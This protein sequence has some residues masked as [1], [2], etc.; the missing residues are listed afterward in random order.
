MKKFQITAGIL[1]LVSLLMIGIFTL[2]QNSLG[3]RL[4][5]QSVTERW[6]ADGTRYAQLSAFI[7][8]SAGV[9]EDS[10]RHSMTSSLDSAYVEASI[11]ANENARLYAY[12]YSGETTVSVS[13]I[14]QETG[15]T[16]KSGVT[17]TA[18][19]VGG[20]FF[21][22]HRLKLLSG[23]YID[24]NDLVLN[25]TIIMDN[26]LAWQF[27]GSPDVVGQS[28]V[29]NGKTCYISGVCEP[30]KAYEEF[31]GENPRIYMSY[32]LLNELVGL[33]V[34]CVETCMPDPVKNFAADILKKSLN[35]PENQIEIIENSARFTDSGLFERLKTFSERSVRTKLVAYPYWENA[36][37]I[38]VDRAAILYVGKLVPIA[39][40]VLLA[41]IELVLAYRNRKRFFGFVGRK[42]TAWW[43]RI[44]QDHRRKVREKLEAKANAQL[45]AA[46]VAAL[47][48]PTPPLESVESAESLPEIK[49]PK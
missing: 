20:D 40:L 25:D 41:V 6:A 22:F 35:A 16:A 2:V 9:D 10:V 26:N 32:S 42:F 49:N 23:S 30:E 34:T 15:M 37:V 24:T 11:D 45:E 27:F 17:A 47:S 48:E 18:A 28:L 29:I 1:A 31:Y 5:D 8:P 36:A 14:N 44:E 3:S 13:K 4:D 46:R 39:L 7:S 19:G 38:L 43:D 21:I 33:N 12:S